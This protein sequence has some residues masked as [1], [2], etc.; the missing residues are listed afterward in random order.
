M[1]ASPTGPATLSIEAWP[2]TPMDDEGVQNAPHRAEQ[3]DER[4]GRTHRRE[5]REAVAHLAVHGIDRTLQRHRH[6]LVQVDAVRQA[7]FVMG[8]GAQTVFGDGA[9][10]VVLR[11][12]VDGFLE[13]A[14]APELLLDDLGTLAA[15]GAG[16]RAS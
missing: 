8:R 11:E 2:L 9:E 16:P 12:A 15:D 4:S 14:R 1:S 13:R 6:P 7:A 5:E 10:I 3:T